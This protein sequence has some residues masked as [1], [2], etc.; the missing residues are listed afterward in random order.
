MARTKLA[1]DVAIRFRDE[2]ARPIRALDLR[3]FSR[4]L[5]TDLFRSALISG[6]FPPELF[7]SVD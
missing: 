7:L 6:A 5:D 3:S 2:A 1:S 4:A